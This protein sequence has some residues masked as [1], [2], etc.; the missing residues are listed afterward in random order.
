MAKDGISI[1][2]NIK[3]CK[4]HCLPSIFNFQKSNSKIHLLLRLILSTWENHSIRSRP[5]CLEWKFDNL[6]I[7]WSMWPSMCSGPLL[8]IRE[9]GRKTVNSWLESFYPNI[10]ALIFLFYIMFDRQRGSRH[11]LVAVWVCVHKILMTSR[12]GPG[13]NRV[14]DMKC[15]YFIMDRAKMWDKPSGIGFKYGTYLAS[16]ASFIG[17]GSFNWIR[18]CGSWI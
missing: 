16:L 9:L 13:N 11:I 12:K 8:E 4:W 17:A 10:L 5:S 6:D 3:G 2:I 14:V 1:I 18:T 15:G 7:A